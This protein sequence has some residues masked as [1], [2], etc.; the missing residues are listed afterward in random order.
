MTVTN[1]AVTRPGSSGMRY[2]TAFLFAVVSVAADQIASRRP[3]K[4]RCRSFLNG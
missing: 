4:W 2:W 1:R 3:R